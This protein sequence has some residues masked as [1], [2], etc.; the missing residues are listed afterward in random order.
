MV[1][2]YYF[3]LL[4]SVS[5]T[6]IRAITPHPVYIEGGLCSAITTLREELLVRELMFSAI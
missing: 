3:P 1:C 2:S 6:S 4:F 5:F